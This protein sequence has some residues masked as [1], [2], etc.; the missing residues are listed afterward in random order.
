VR[1]ETCAGSGVRQSE[2]KHCMMLKERPGLV[3]MR[4][5]ALSHLAWK[6]ASSTGEI[7]TLKEEA[8][9]VVP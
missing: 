2:F 5:V 4:Y 8:I 1:K 9:V 7:Q 3:Y 6:P